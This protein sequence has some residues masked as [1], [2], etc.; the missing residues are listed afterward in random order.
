MTIPNLISV[1]RLLAVPFIIWLISIQHYSSAFWIFL[2]AGVSDG[3]DGFIAKRFNQT[4]ELGAYLDPIADKVMLVA[5]FLS[6]GIQ[7]LLPL[8]LVIL[9]ISRDLLIVGAVMLSWV[10]HQPIQ[11]KPLMVSKANTV[12]QIVLV[13]LVMAAMGFE[14]ELGFVVTLTVFLTAALTLLSTLAYLLDWFGH[15]ADLEKKS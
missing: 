4:T 9:V 2:L 6:L 14:L 5:V 1:C 8:W 15:M 3:V 11:V 13:C 7:G 12:S 10:L